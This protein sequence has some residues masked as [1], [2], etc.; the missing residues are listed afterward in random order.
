LKREKLEVERLAE[1][2]TLRQAA[3]AKKR[4]MEYVERIASTPTTHVY[5]ERIIPAPVPETK[6]EGGSAFKKWFKEYQ[7]AGGDRPTTPSTYS[8]RYY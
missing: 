6:K 3:G 5:V 8:D 4:A 7:E 1:Q 2:Q